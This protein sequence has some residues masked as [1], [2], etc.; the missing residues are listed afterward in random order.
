MRVAPFLQVLDE[1]TAKSS[2][3]DPLK[4][5]PLIFSA[6]VT[7]VSVNVED[8]A[9]LVLPTVIEPNCKDAGNNVAVGRGAVPIPDKLTVCCPLLVLS[10]TVSVAERDPVAEGVKVTVT[11]QVLD[12]AMA[13]SPGFV[14]L[15]LS[16]EIFNVAIV[17]VSVNVEL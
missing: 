8:R 11:T 12:D 15:K 10:L 1:A 4:L 3:S 14:P 13:K 6:T 2:A 5:M 9:A 7:L 17:L 16:V